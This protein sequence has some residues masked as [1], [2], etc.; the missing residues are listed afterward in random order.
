MAKNPIFYTTLIETLSRSVHAFKD[1]VWSFFSHMV[2][3]YRKRKQKCKK[4][5]IWNFANVYTTLVE[6]LPRS[7]HDFLI[8][9][10]MYFQRRCRLKFCFVHMVPC[11]NEKKKK[12][13][14]QK[15]K[16][17]KK[18]WFG[19]E[20]WWKVNLALIYLTGSGETVF[21]DGGRTDDGL[22]RD[23]SSSAVQCHKA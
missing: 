9:S 4:F 11:W 23:Y 17:L 13:K 10:V 3:C 20:I 22:P 1:V 21:T 7:M 14:S 19:V 8:E 5:K 6:T 18:R 16:I 12:E 15:C 2:P